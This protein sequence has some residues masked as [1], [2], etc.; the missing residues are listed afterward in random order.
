VTHEVFEEVAMNQTFFHIECH[1]N[2]KKSVEQ[3]DERSKIT[4]LRKWEIIVGSSRNKGQQG[5][6]FEITKEGA[7]RLF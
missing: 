6:D 2:D 7:T 5:I 4:K 1:T 3:N